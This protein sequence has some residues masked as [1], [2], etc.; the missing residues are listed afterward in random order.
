MTNVDRSEQ[1]KALRILAEAHSIPDSYYDLAKERYRSFET[2][3]QR[4]G[5]PLAKYGPRSGFTKPAW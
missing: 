2:W 5:R 1:A 4:E 3:L